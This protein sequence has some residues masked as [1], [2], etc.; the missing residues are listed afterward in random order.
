MTTHPQPS[1]RSHGQHIPVLSRSK[2][3]IAKIPISEL[4]GP[5]YTKVFYDTY[6]PIRLKITPQMRARV[7]L[8]LLPEAGYVSHHTAVQIWGGVVPDSSDVHVSYPRRETRCQRQG[9]AAHFAGAGASTT[10]REGM[11][12]STPTQAFLELAASGVGLIDLVVAGDSL[13]KATGLAPKE[14]VD[15][16]KEWRGNKAKLAREA[17]GLIRA[18]VDSPMETRI[19]LLVVLAGLPEP[20]VNLIIRDEDGAWVWRFDL[21]YEQWKL[22]I[23]YDGRQHALDEDQWG[24]DIDRREQ[25]DQRGWRLLIVRAGG[26]YNDPERTLRRIRDALVERGATG[27]PA[28]FKPAW[29]RYFPSRV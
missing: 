12:I 18:G 8:Q 21:C 3:R 2:A 15:A 4:L 28:R 26:V 16:A 19:R 29:Q 11:R 24:G 5:I 23:E 17:A 20:Q 13:V 6:V 7:A 10:F 22:I 1:A 25:L 9:I 27:L 14:F